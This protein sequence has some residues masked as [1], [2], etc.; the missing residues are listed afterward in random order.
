MGNLGK[1]KAKLS[2]DALGKQEERMKK[3][4]FAIQSMTKEEKEN[5]EI[6]EKE[7]SRLQRIAKGSGTSTTDIRALI[8]QYKMIKEFM[9]TGQDMDMSKG[10]NLSQKQ[11]QKLAKKFGKKMRL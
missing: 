8:K 4:K 1:A 7:T 5:P 3:F 2:D 10:M 11:L 6:M 9:K